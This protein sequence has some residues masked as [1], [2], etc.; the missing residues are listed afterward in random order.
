M[1]NVNRKRIPLHE[2]AEIRLRIG[3]PAG[4]AVF[5]WLHFVLGL[6]YV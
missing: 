5:P 2:M 3:L 4:I 1:Y 6:I